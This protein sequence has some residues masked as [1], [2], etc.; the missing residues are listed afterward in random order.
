MKRPTVVLRYLDDWAAQQLQPLAA[1][2]Q[3]KLIELQ[4][5]AAWAEQFDPFQPMVG[6]LQTNLTDDKGAEIAS[7]VSVAKRCPLMPI[8]VLSDVK[9]PEDDRSLWTSMLLD[10]GASLVLYPPLTRVMLEEAAIGLMQE[11]LT[12]L[13]LNTPIDLAM[14]PAE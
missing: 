3:W 6:F 10:C 9:L 8:V 11:R 14:E 4:R 7:L 2:H 1:T 12:T 5:L 13:R